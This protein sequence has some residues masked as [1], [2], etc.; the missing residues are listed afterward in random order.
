MRRLLAILTTL[1]LGL[2]VA[3]PGTAAATPSMGL[4]PTAAEMDQLVALATSVIRQQTEVLVR[5]SGV[6]AGSVPAAGLAHASREFID[7]QSPRLGEL[8]ARRDVLRDWGEEYTDAHVDLS[9]LSF[10]A[11]DGSVVLHT[12]EHTSLTYARIRGD[13]PPALEFVT[14]RIFAFAFDGSGWSLVDQAVD[15]EGP[16]PINEPTGATADQMRQALATAQSATVGA[17]ALAPDA[18]DPGSKTGP[19]N[20]QA[21]ANYANQYWD[22]YN[23]AYRTFADTGGDCTNFVSQAMRAGGWSDKTGWW[24]DDDNW[25]YN[26]LNQTRTWINVEYFYTF[27]AVRSHRTTILSSPWSLLLADVLQMDFT[28]NGSKDHTM[29]VTW[30]NAGTPYLSYHTTDTHNRSLSSLLTQYPLSGTRYIPHRT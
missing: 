26:S 13:E 29:I 3:T 5:G 30:W 4:S 17:S 16:L 15:S 19:Y 12:E 23:P 25:W 28:N 24:L 11:M 18:I 14:P 10:D 8:A 7:G 6:W 2:A 1:A 9:L 27:A 20:Y 21:M 22:N